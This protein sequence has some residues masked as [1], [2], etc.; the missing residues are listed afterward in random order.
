MVAKKCCQSWKKYYHLKSTFRFKISFWRIK[1]FMII[2]N[3]LGYSPFLY[4]IHC[5]K[6]VQWLPLKNNK[7]SFLLQDIRNYRC[8]RKFK[9]K[10]KKIKS[11]LYT[12]VK[13]TRIIQRNI[14]SDHWCSY[15]NKWDWLIYN[16][17]IIRPD[18]VRVY[19]QICLIG[20][21][22]IVK[23]WTIWFIF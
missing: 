20:V 17:P 15:D 7:W 16:G 11:T 12:Y 5:T 13:K 22:Q 3:I 21:N 19:K 18:S 14:W 2:I 9:K 8:E 10:I 23:F 4:P 1:I 6:C